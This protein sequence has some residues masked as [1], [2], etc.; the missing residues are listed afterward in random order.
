MAES[1]STAVSA[2]LRDVSHVLV[3]EDDTDASANLRD[4]LELDDFLVSTASSIQ[5][6]LDHIAHT[7]VEM[8]ILDRRLPDGSAEEALPRLKAKAPD[9]A[10]VIITGYADLD[11]VITALREGADDYLLKPVNPDLLRNTL[12]RIR[13]SQQLALEKRRSEDAFRAL[14]EAAGC[15]IVIVKPDRTISYFNS[16]SE[17]LTGY[18]AADALGRDF[19][20]TFLPPE[21]RD[22]I[23]RVFSCVLEGGNLRNYQCPLLRRDGSRA[24]LLWNARRLDDY[25]AEPVLLA[26]GQDITSLKEAQ[27]RA[28][29]AERL[30]AI[31]QMVAGLAHESRNALQRSQ[32][33]LEMLELE[34]GE[35]AEAQDLLRRIQ[36]AQDQLHKLFDEVRGY[37][38]PIQLDRCECQLSEIWREAWELLAAQR[39][40]R[41]AELRER[42]HTVDLHCEVDRFRMVQVFRNLLENSLAAC[43]DPVVIEVSCQ[44]AQLHNRD[45]IRVSVCDNGPGLTAEQRN[46]VFEPFYTTKTQGTGLGMPIALRIVTAHEGD[47]AVGDSGHPGAEMIVTLPRHKP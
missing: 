29:H 36:K 35:N 45:A 19:F 47:L 34:L 12:A 32:A 9:A 14:I 42:P 15:M 43:H 22:R 28:L 20:A 1:T 8:I 23:H 17:E 6:A 18:P 4:I 16:F 37:V 25:S 30:A 38:A 26:V 13:N 27:D 40:G 31:G 33:C 11:G 41:K 10:V 46:R 39:R 24:F 5:A 21:D 3:I 2:P 44:K 7:Q